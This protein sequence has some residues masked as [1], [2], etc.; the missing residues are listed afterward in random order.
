MNLYIGIDPGLS[1]AM[2]VINE[3]GKIVSIVDAPTIKTKT[4]KK[5]RT[6]LVDTEMVD[7]LESW[8]DTT[9]NSDSIKM[10]TIE[11]V[12]AMPGQGVTSMFSMGHGFGLWLGIIAALRIPVTRVE[13]IRWKK[14]MGI[15]GKSDKGA[16]VVR[17][18][19]LYPSCR[20]LTRDY[21]R[22]GDTLQTLLHGRAD[23]LL[24]AEWGR[25]QALH[26]SES[27]LKS[28]K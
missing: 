7:F 3:K 17:A 27:R 1:G 13:P 23:A 12:H 6:L 4:G 18:L 9:G 22:G 16:S 26:G 28:L 20:E 24:I 10:V 11:N 2:A 15:A 19:Q 21:R 5:N 14:E 25:T 8:N